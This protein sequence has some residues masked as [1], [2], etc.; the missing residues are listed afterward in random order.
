MA[1]YDN[2]Y[3]YKGQNTFDSTKNTNRGGYNFKRSIGTNYM[4]NTYN[5]YKA[6]TGFITRDDMLQTKLLT[7]DE[8]LESIANTG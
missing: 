6:D 8:N 3:T 2:K 7:E 1:A 4:S 5:N